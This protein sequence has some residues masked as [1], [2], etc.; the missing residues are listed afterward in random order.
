MARFD[1]APFARCA[2]RGSCRSDA[3]G[4]IA[5]EY[6]GRRIEHQAI[7]T[8]EFAVFGEMLRIAVLSLVFALLSALVALSGLLG[9]AGW[10]ARTYVLVF[11]ALFIVVATASA[12]WRRPYD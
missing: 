1:G 5:T 2:R 4:P 6:P 7:P 8:F 12:V 11:L 9:E 3:D 10:L